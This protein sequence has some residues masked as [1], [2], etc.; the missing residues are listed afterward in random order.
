VNR[1]RPRTAATDAL[2]PAGEPFAAL[3]AE[4]LLL[5]E[6]NAR[7][8][9]AQHQRAELARLLGRARALP[10]TAADAATLGDD[11]AQMLI[12]G[13]VIRE[14]LLELC[15]EIERAMVGFGAR[16]EALASPAVEQMISPLPDPKGD[17]NGTHNGNGN[18]NGHGASAA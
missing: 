15:E 14:S 4:V 3:H 11:A 12:D 6:E 17:R 13:L 16:L 2:D 18:G 1:R 10:D 9:G 7:L 8:R 5:R